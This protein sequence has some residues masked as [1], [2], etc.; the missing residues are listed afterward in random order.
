VTLKHEMRTA[1]PA[2][3]MAHRDPSLAAADDQGFNS[4]DRHETCAAPGR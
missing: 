3:L 2:Q 1:A 4:F